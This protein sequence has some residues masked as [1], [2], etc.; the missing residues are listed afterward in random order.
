MLL[1]VGLN[2]YK[3]DK[4][5]C[6]LDKSKDQLWS[7]FFSGKCDKSKQDNK[8]KKIKTKI[9]TKEEQVAFQSQGV[10]GVEV[11]VIVAKNLFQQKRVSKGEGADSTGTKERK[12]ILPVPAVGEKLDKESCN[13]KRDG[14]EEKVPPQQESSHQ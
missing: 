1:A 10:G 9:A 7:E 6:R 8:E 4:A 12:K 2:Y 13:T 11:A 14:K 3:S 5:Y